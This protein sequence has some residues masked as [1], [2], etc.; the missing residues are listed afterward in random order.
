MEEQDKE[1]KKLVLKAEGRDSKGAGNASATISI[2][3]EDLKGQT[4]VSV[5]TDLSVTGKV[6]QFGRGVMA[7]ISSKLMEQFAENLQKE[8][9][10]DSEGESDATKEFEKEFEKESTKEPEAETEAVDILEASSSKSVKALGNVAGYSVKA[11]RGVKN[12]FKKKPTES[13]E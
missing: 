9:A 5:L 13:T 1:A 12:A 10:N 4:K 3:L 2:Q 8:L 11:A 7:D 6:A